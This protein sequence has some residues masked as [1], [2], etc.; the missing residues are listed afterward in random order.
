MV[1]S[2]ESSP[3]WRLYMDGCG[4]VGGVD[5]E[6][7]KMSICRRSWTKVVEDALVQCKTS[8]VNDG[9]KAENGFKAGFQMDLE[10]G[11]RKLLS[12]TDILV[13]PHINSKI[14]VWKKEYG[15]LCDLFN[16]S[17][18]GWNSTTFTLKIVDEA[19]W[20]AQKRVNP[21]VR[22]LRFKSWSYYEQ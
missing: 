13:I 15:T 22:A 11:I 16:K 19:V 8:I 18:I 9:W 6:K 12:G 17:G 10:K 1:N 14:H 2:L 21:S 7:G 20:D 5:V 4:S 3:K